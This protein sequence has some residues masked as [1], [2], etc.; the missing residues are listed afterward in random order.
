ML[1]LKAE[2]LELNSRTH[3]K[4]SRGIVECVYNDTIWESMQADL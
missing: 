1:V 3:V 2:K 4:T